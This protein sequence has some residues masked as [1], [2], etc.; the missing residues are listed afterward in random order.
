[1]YHL[2]GTVH[3]EADDQCAACHYFSKGVAC[4][5][6]EALCTGVVSLTGDIKV[7]N[8]GFYKPFK[9]ALQLVGPDSETIA[10]LVE[11]APLS[12]EDPASSPPQPLPPSIRAL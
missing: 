4:P 11:K 3:I 12:N 8:C 5:L 1:M 10:P 9:R 2:N 6:L 7:S